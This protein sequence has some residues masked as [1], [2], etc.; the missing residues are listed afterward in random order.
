MRLARPALAVAL[1]AS[2]T[3]GGLA[4]ADPLPGLG[5]DPQCFAHTT[6]IDPMADA[7][8][9]PTNPLWIAR[10]QLNQYCATLRLRDQAASPAYGKANLT[11]GAQEQ[12]RRFQEQIADGPAHIKGGVTP[13]VPG[14]Q[15][16]DAFRSIEDWERLTGGKVTRVSFPASDGAKLYGTLRTP[17]K[18]VPEPRTGYPGI[19]ITDGS[20]T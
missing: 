14:S 15:A 17:P 8:G 10:D 20:Q 6:R 3:A 13:L 2:L 11:L 18:S 7:T 19:V 4:S 1:L 5:V 12:A 16:A 9:T